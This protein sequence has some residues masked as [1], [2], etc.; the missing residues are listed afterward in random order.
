MDELYDLSN[1]RKHTERMIEE[2]VKN[3]DVKEQEKYLFTVRFWVR[4]GII[5]MSAPSVVLLPPPWE[6]SEK[7]TQATSGPYSW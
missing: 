2:I 1:A 3:T 7:S 6:S 4:D 5:E